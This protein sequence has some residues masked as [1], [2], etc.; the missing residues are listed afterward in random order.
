MKK[1]IFLL[2][3]VIS[4]YSFGQSVDGGL[5]TLTASGTDTY[6]ITEALP[7]AY[8]PKERFIV[9]FANPNTITTPTLNRAA[10]GAKFIKNADGT[11]PSVGAITGRVLLSYNGT[12]YQIVGGGGSAGGGSG[13]V[14]NVAALTLGTTGTDLSSSV[15]NPTT[16]PV[17]TL[18]VP[19]ASG[20]NRGALSASDWSTFN[21]KQATGLSYLLASGGTATGTNTFAMGAFPFIMTTG[22]TTGTGATAG[23]Q[24]VG[25]SLTTGN[26]FD[27]SSSSVSSGALGVYTS[28]ST[29]IN[30]TEGTNGLVKV[31]MSGANSTASK[32]AIGLYS[33]VINTGT[34]NTNIAGYFE[35]SGGTTNL[36]LRTL[37]NVLIAN[38][39]GD[40][41]TASTRLDVR[42]ISG[43]TNIARFATFGDTERLA[44]KEAGSIAV[45]SSEGVNGQVLTSAGI[46]NPV[47]WTS[48]NILYLPLITSYTGAAGSDASLETATAIDRIPTT[49]M[50]VGRR[51]SAI[52]TIS[53]TQRRLYTA[54]LV[55]PADAT[56]NI[57]VSPSVIRPNDFNV[58]TNNKVWREIK[59]SGIIDVSNYGVVPGAIFVSD[60]INAIMT[61]ASSNDALIFPA[62]DYN[63]YAMTIT[64]KLTFEGHGARFISPALDISVLSITQDGVVV[65]GFDFI[66]Q[67]RASIYTNQRA[68]RI[69]S[70]SNVRIEDCF[71]DG[72]RDSALS[73]NATHISDTSSD[74]GGINVVNCIF[75]RNNVG[76][77][78]ATRGEYVTIS[79]CSFVDNN[80]GLLIGAGNIIVTGCNIL[81]SSTVGVDLVTGTNDAHGIFTGNQIN[82]N[83][84]SVRGVGIVNGHFFRGNNIYYGDMQFTNCIG[85]EFSN[86]TI[87]SV[88]M[89]YDNC[90]GIKVE[91]NHMPN[92]GTTTLTTNW[93]GNPS[94]VFAYNNKT[95]ANAYL[96]GWNFSDLGTNA[97]RV[98]KGWFTD[99]EIGTGNIA[100]GGGATA[101]ELRFLEPSGSGTNYLGFKV[102]ALAGNL[103]FTWF[104]AYPAVNGYVLSAT[105]AGVMSWIAPGGGGSGLTYA[106]T[107][108]IAMKIK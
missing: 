107:K 11:N 58:S 17:I 99:I 80:T 79:G 91:D 33:K 56:A 29:V 105:T 50:S 72:Y 27:A 32:T 13:T 106:Q 7:A 66:G 19:T 41:P 42:G 25:N 20:S 9:S 76:F 51:V 16:T 70:C 26:L 73:T 57:E 63:V 47:T 82:H 60:Q 35:A 104:D 6:T 102:P 4:I 61:A 44:F 1:L 46:G 77:H 75:M 69:S 53:G 31:L 95:F 85:I 28:T 59:Q 94:T 67:G 39:S 45:G 40:T 96:S 48:L 30:H 5:K 97:A 12:Y 65:R 87:E 10:L 89:Q 62:G 3:L 2:L 34:T 78:A 8:D 21:G 37:G 90:T 38:A 54:E 86:N 55:V 68:I 14:T 52:V 84:L 49:S 103:D 83:V 74:F 101:S 64:K 24:L 108:A 81:D 71:F 43:G 92:A 15:A 98:T 23:H 36:A 18:N 22:V 93:N 100:L 88:I